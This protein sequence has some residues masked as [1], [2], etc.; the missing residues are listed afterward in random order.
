MEFE[1]VSAGVTL[2]GFMIQF[3]KNIFGLA[4]ANQVIPVSPIAPGATCAVT[5]PLTQNAN[6]VS[7]APATGTL[8]VAIKSNQLGVLYLTDT[9]DASIVLSESGK[10]DSTS[11]VSGW[12]A[13]PETQEVQQELQNVSISDVAVATT[14][15]ERKN[16]F[17]MAH[18]TVGEEQVLYCTGKVDVPGA[19]VQALLELRFS[20]GK[21]GVRAYYR[22]TRQDLAQ[23]VLAA[24]RA[25]LA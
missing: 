10:I 9:I 8:Q 12:K 18:K 11:F 19:P 25:A 21:G 15:L 20:T 24:V 16:V 5:V 7:P 22:S 6:L 4:P 3:N 13:I 14:Q 17:V 23:V 1:N 2:D